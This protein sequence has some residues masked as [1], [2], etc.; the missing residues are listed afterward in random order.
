MGHRVLM[1]VLTALAF[2]SLAAVP[3]GAQTAPDGWTV[4]RTVDGHA[5][6]QG[7]WANNSAT[8]LERPEQLAGRAT[9]TEEEQASLAARAAELFS[10]TG[11]AA[12][13]D[14]VF[15]AALADPDEYTSSDG[16]T[17][18]YNAF[19]VVERGFDN[20][21]S[22]IVDPPDGRIP[23]TAEAR[24]VRASLDPQRSLN[25][26]GPEDAGLNVRCISYGAP[27]LFAGYNSYFQ[28][29]QTSSHV[30]IVQEMIHDA[31]VILLGDQPHIGD[32]LRQRHGDSRG[33]W[34]GDTLVVETTNYLPNEGSLLAFLGG[35]G[36]EN[37]RVVERFTRLGPDTVRWALTFEDP[38]TWTQP[39]TAEIMLSKSDDA[40]F[41]YACH[42][43]NYGL[44]GILVGTRKLERTEAATGAS[45]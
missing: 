38:A 43:G 37:R 3:A 24:A 12:F 27:Y 36:G 35:G 20:R 32:G 4:P 6:L 25:P 13:G 29:L 7:V 33:H 41:E 40:V 23:L 19:W 30:V 39:W 34:E 28:I 44:E 1:S 22:L 14:S 10:G 17:G 26:V 15:Q 31:R 11:D 42:E 16:G 45:R 2:G 8:P 21:T 9:L 18:N 5:D